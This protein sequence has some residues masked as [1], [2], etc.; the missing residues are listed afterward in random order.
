MN[1]I[2]DAVAAYGKGDYPTVLR[3]IRPLANQGHADAQYNLG[4]M[5]Y[6]GEG[7]PQD[8]VEAV[9]WC[10]LA[11]DQG[12]AFAQSHLGTMY[13]KGHGVP[14]NY[15]EAAK[16]YRLADDQGDAFG[17]HNLGV[18]Y[19]RGE[20]LPQNY[21]EAAKWYRLAADQGHA[22]AQFNLGIMFYKGG[23][24]PQNCVEAAKWCRLAAD[25]G[26]ASAQSN[27][28]VL[29]YR[30]EGVPQDKVHAYMWFDLAAA[31]DNQNAI[32]N[33]DAA[34]KLMTPAQIA[35]AKKLA[36]GWKPTTQPIK[37]FKMHPESRQTEPPITN[38]LYQYLA[39]MLQDLRS[40]Q[41]NAPS[42]DPR[43]R[44]VEQFII[45]FSEFVQ[46][47]TTDD[48][49]RRL[50]NEIIWLQ[51][52]YSDFPGLDTIKEILLSHTPRYKRMI[53]EFMR[54]HFTYTMSGQGD[55]RKLSQQIDTLFRAG[56]LTDE[57]VAGFRSTLK[58]SKTERELEG[59][60]LPWWKRIFR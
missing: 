51:A 17:Q 27:L 2:E 25:Q 11:A 22:D 8:Y 6:R 44:R 21:A 7:V 38:D 12:H 14:Q 9:R 39:E 28:A 55:T 24:V 19:H 35:E 43:I 1:A 58:S 59:M 49:S 54:A 47:P 18:M 36:R 4:L 45:D 32:R 57:Q 23:G 41:L 10:R 3:L 37:Q 16:W 33:R 20:G 50:E 15:V 56:L 42:S 30:G 13:Y 31:Q 26:D 29:Y 40:L 52:N 34:A 5:Y 46:N 60:F 53:A 48:E